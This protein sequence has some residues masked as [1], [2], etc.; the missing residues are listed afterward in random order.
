MTPF[1]LTSHDVCL[2]V[3]QVDGNCTGTYRAEFTGEFRNSK[4]VGGLLPVVTEDGVHHVMCTEDDGLDENDVYSG[5]IG[6]DGMTKG[7]ETNFSKYYMFYTVNSMYCISVLLFSVK[8]D[9]NTTHL[10]MYSV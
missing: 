1:R 3:T 8:I 7:T 6:M 2:F 9:F 5:I 10:S 4:I